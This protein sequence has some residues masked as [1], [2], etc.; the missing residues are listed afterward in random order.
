MRPVRVATIRAPRLRGALSLSRGD[1][2]TTTG[3]NAMARP[4]KAAAVAELTE[5]FRESNAVVLT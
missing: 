1:C 4:D 3:R 2:G 5:S